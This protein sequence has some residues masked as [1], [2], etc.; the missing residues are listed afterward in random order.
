MRRLAAAQPRRHQRQG[1]EGR[2][3]GEEQGRP[4]ARGDDHAG[5]EHGGLAGRAA[6][7]MEDLDRTERAVGKTAIALV[8]E[9]VA[10][11]DARGDGL[12]NCLE[13]V[14]FRLAPALALLI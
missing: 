9:S 3:Q 12:V 6:A 4:V 5:D 10:G 1:R 2:E 13:L 8:N 7:A 14:S 11:A